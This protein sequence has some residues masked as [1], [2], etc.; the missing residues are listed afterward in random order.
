MK[1]VVILV[2]CIMLTTGFSIEYSLRIKALGPDFAYLIP[3]YETDLYRDPN[4]YTRDNKFLAVFPGV[5]FS[6]K[7]LTSRFG[8]MGRYDYIYNYDDETSEYWS[9]V[10]GLSLRDLWMWDARKLL[11][12]FLGDVWNFTDDLYWYNS[13][14]IDIG[15]PQN[16]EHRVNEIKYI[17]GI[18]GSDSWGSSFRYYGYVG[19]GVY[20]YL[21]SWSNNVWHQDQTL[22]FTAGRA[23]VSYRSA[24]TENNF[25]SGYIEFGSP[26]TIEEIDVLPW[27]VLDYLLEDE[28]AQMLNFLNTLISRLAFVKGIPVNDQSFVAVGFCDQFLFQRFNEAY[29]G[30]KLTGLG[31][32]LS[33]PLGIEYRINAVAVR[34]G[35]AVKHI[36]TETSEEPFLS[37]Q[38]RIDHKLTYASYCGVGWIPGPN[39]AIDLYKKGISLDGSME[40]SLKFLF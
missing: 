25:A 28:D 16:Y 27:P 24:P 12:S 11:P 22:V 35:T 32:T 13:R 30:V 20:H 19:L 14:Y 33:F 26:T 39:F 1:K 31:N 8:L 23:G 21:D 18:P 6:L 10:I 38:H 15:A 29:T 4:L 9:K 3:D 37:I 5:P 40:I 17:F 34:M 7:L 2:G 36:Y